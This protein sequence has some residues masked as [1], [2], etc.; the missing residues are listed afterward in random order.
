MEIS[1][2][3]DS[4]KKVNFSHSTKLCGC[5]VQHS[6]SKAKQLILKGN[7]KKL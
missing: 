1:D 7:T 5:E 2:D 3:A 6:S 4:E